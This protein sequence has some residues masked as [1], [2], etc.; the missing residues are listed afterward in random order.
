MGGTDC[1]V[2]QE[3]PA[4]G[5]SRKG[6]PSS[7]RRA[8]CTIPVGKGA[9]GLRQRHRKRLPAAFAPALSGAAG[10]QGDQ[11]GNI[12]ELAVHAGGKG[13]CGPDGE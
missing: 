7:D 12:G 10:G 2:A 8:D 5:A 9:E 1:C 13:L 4:S 6:V 3:R 11:T